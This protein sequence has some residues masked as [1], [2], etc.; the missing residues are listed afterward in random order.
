MVLKLAV[1]D[2]SR[3]VV[4]EIGTIDTIQCRGNQGKREFQGLEAKDD[5]RFREVG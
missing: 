4:R 5:A 1:V 2:E 3:E